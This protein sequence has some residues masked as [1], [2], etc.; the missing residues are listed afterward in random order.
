MRPGRLKLAVILGAA[1]LGGLVLASWTQPWFT[2]V[3]AGAQPVVVTG[4]VAAPA[5]S[6]L[7]LAALALAAALSIAGPVVRY[8]L[9]G[10][11]LLIGALAATTSVVAIANPIRASLPAVTAVVGESGLTAVSALVTS[12]SVSAWPWIAV[13]LGVLTA[14]LGAVTLVTG[15]RWPGPTRKY[16][17]TPSTDDSPAASW[18]ALSAGDDPTR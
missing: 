15:R 18:D 17:S 10:L 3:V 8:V 14:A 1:G 13:L 11:H 6:A 9:G 5:L 4:Q 12:V 2:L 16:E 7:G